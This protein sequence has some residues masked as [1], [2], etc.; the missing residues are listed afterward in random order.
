MAVRLLQMMKRA[1]RTR[2][3]GAVSKNPR[4]EPYAAAVSFSG[5]RL[6]PLATLL[7]RAR[8]RLI[9]RT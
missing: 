3:S 2:A 7:R 8:T 9:L 6:S 4:G 1:E 5:N